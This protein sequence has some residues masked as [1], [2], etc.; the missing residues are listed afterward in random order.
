MFIGKSVCM[1]LLISLCLNCTLAMAQETEATDGLIKK[2]NKYFQQ[3]DYQQAM[4]WYQKAAAK[5]YA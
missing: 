3:T 2:A 5:G 1:S 4:Y